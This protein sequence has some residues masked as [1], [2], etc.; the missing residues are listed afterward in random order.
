MQE[1]PCTQERR[2]ETGKTGTE[3]RAGQRER[4]REGERGGRRRGRIGQ[5]TTRNQQN[6]DENLA[7]Y[8]TMRLYMLLCETM[9]SGLA[10]PG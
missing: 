1:Y 7:G 10:S 9:K 4:E 5:G 6:Y 3:N 2:G 8:D